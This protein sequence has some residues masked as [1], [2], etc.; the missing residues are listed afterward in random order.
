MRMEKEVYLGLQSLPTPPPR[1][2]CLPNVLLRCL[3]I[4]VEPIPQAEKY[5]ITPCH[6]D[7][8]N[9]LKYKYNQSV[10]WNILTA[11]RS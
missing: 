2:L 9:S 4:S 1:F 8:V 6:V 7:T 11:L 5:Y 3:D 10:F